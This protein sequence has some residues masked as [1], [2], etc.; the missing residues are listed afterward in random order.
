MRLGSLCLFLKKALGLSYIPHLSFG[1]AIQVV[2]L[3]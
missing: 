2:Y 3:V 1:K